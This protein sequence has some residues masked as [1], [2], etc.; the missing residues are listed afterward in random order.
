MKP[1]TRGQVTQKAN[2]A[3]EVMQGFRLW[4]AEQIE[5]RERLE[6]WMARQ[7]AAMEASKQH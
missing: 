6:V 7:K 4:L 1:S 3:A 2:R 5:A